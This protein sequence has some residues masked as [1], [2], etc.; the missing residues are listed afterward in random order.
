MI[1]AQRFP[2]DF[3]GIIAGA[4]AADYSGLKFAQAWR[5]KALADK[6]LTEADVGRLAD[7]ILERCDG[8]DGLNDGLINDPRECDFVVERDLPRCSD[9]G[10]DDCFRTDQIEALN[11]YYAPVMLAG[12]Q[13]YPP[14]PVGSETSG[15][16][17]DGVSRTGWIPWLINENGRTLLDMLGSDF[18]RYMAFV[19]DDPAY[20][21][22]DFDFAEVP[23][24]IEEFRAIVDALDPDLSAFKERGGKLISYFGWADPD[25][26]PL[27]AVAY[28]DEVAS[29]S[30]IDEFYRLYMVPGLFH[31]RGGPGYTRFD[32]LT[33]L[34]NWVEGDTQP[35][36][37]Q[38][39]RMRGDVK[40]TRPLCPHPSRATYNGVGPDDQAESFE[41]A[42]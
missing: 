14:H 4:P 31:C 12:K 29:R 2:E 13:V 9:A 3:D 6:P 21:W 32:L 41:C 38:A 26:N 39:T 36:A 28:F 40:Q 42:Q 30:A 10:G 23:D 16:G 25:I 34:I 27:T 24:N 20:N 19:Q 18:F 37:I 35:D 17:Y 11:A 7:A 22:V 5:S 15:P 1:S 33:P 8:L